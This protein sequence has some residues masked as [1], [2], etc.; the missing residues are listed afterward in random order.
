MKR[1]TNYK[2]HI[3]FLLLGLGLITSCKKLVE[4]SS[5]VTSINGENV[6]NNDAS[7]TAVLNGL[8]ISMYQSGFTSGG[9]GLYTI[10]GRSGLSADELT[11]YSGSTNILLQAH[12]QNNLSSQLVVGPWKDCYKFLQTVNSLLEGLP[13]S[14][15]LSA[16]VKQQLEGEA[17]FLRAFY[18]FYLVNFYGD[19]PLI[20]SSDWRVNATITRTQKSLVWQ[21]IVSDLKDAQT[22]LSSNFLE[23]D[24][25]TTS[26]DRVR[27]TKWAATALL[28]R[29]YL[30]LND[31]AN[32]EAQSTAVISN[33]S[34]FDTVSLNKVFLKNSKEAIWQIMPVNVN[35]NTTDANSFIL[36]SDPNSQQPTYISSFLLNSFETGDRR[37]T[38]WMSVYTSGTGT[39]YYPSKYMANRIT[40][41]NP[42]TPPT[43]YLMVIRLAEM[44]LIRAEA[45]AQLNNVSG[46]Q[47]DLNVLRARAGLI[48]TIAA[49]KASLLTAILHER[50]VELFTEWGHRWFDLI[51][52]GNINS[53]MTVVTAA[54]TS[55][56]ISWKPYQQLYP[57]NYVDIQL[58]PNLTQTVGY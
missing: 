33:S 1:I 7:A 32:A 3:A 51:R 10:A 31:W 41:T 34:L 39:Y 49:D 27:P 29:V 24:V 48:N 8:Y 42:P 44:Y 50:Q 36:V 43:E 55:G 21:Q 35:Q 54:K 23:A 22:L 52:S 47:A 9:S 37:K 25:I 19:V 12:Y 17:K 28:A 20:T 38:N 53:V 57:L 46:A 18:Y 30:Y 5:P 45:R 58:D 2:S 14:T 6:Y 16:K 56:A 4:V 13:K 40:P 26:S 11:L 15:G